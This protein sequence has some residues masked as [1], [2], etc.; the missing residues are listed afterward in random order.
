MN[1]LPTASNMP[2][3]LLIVNHRGYLDVM[4]GHSIGSK[5]R[6]SVTKAR[7]STSNPGRTRL[8]PIRVDRLRAA[9]K[10]DG[11]PWPDIARALGTSYPRL[12]HLTDKAGP[13]HRRCRRPVFDGFVKELRVDRPWLSGDTDALPYVVTSDAAVVDI[14]PAQRGTWIGRRAS[15]WKEQP[16]ASPLIQLAL[17]RLLAQADAAL[18]RDFARVPQ[19]VLAKVLDEEFPIDD[20][21]AYGLVLITEALE[22][23]ID[24]VRPLPPI[25]DAEA[26]RLSGIQHMDRILT[27]WFEGM[28]AWPDWKRL[29]DQI[30]T[31]SETPRGLWV[32]LAKDRRDALF[33]L[34]ERIEGQT[35]LPRARTPKR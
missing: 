30:P 22:V 2:W 14:D 5:G 18:R 19:H 28:G 9:Q 7:R 17:D 34:Y 25:R 31:D 12:Y 29:H 1:E 21:R 33:Q 20:V 3:R 32:F 16:P 27:P 15:L 35:T 6:E 4:L 24:L 11:R 8:V 10:L 13:D 23:G 26:L